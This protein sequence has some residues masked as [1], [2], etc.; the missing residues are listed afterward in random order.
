LDIKN[1]QQQ[2]PGNRKNSKDPVKNN[3]VHEY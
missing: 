2:L 1:Q 3:S